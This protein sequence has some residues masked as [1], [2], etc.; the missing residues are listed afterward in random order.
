MDL[1]DWK[2]KLSKERKILDEVTKSRGIRKR[3][4]NVLYKLHDNIA[5]TKQKRTVKMRNLNR[6]GAV[7]PSDYTS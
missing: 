7:T 4:E 3:E 1:E 5:E 2:V 6:S